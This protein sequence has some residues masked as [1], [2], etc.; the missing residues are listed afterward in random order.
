[1]SSE[2]LALPIKPVINTTSAVVIPNGTVGASSIN[3]QDAKTSG[4]FYDTDA[5]SVSLVI[6]GVKKLN[7]DATNVEVKTRV[8]LNGIAHPGPGSL[9]GAGILY[10]ASDNSYG[11]YWRLGNNNSKDLL[12]QAGYFYE[13]KTTDDTKTLMASIDTQYNEAQVVKAI[14]EATNTGATLASSFEIR[15]LFKN[16]DGVVTRVGA[17]ATSTITDSA[18]AATL[19]VNGTSVD[20]M[21][22]GAVATTV[23]WKAHIIVRDTL[24][25]VVDEE[26]E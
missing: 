19:E 22:T 16:T 20:L 21:V 25:S 12:A 15:G 11:L 1:M 5:S 14:V 24:T 7:I 23:R 2:G 6:G 10:A 17:L 8:V 3:F 26:E 4:M 9:Q 18:W 13:T